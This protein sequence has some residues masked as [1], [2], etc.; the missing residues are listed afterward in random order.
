V[1]NHETGHQFGYHH[2][3]CPGAGRPA[4]VMQQQTLGLKGCTA[5]P[6]PVLNGSR[7][8]GPPTSRI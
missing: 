6:W 2:E 3:L 1:I 7:Y 4:P 8:A 5:N